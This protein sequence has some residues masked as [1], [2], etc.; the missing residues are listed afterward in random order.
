MSSLNLSA[1]PWW[2]ADQYED[3][4]R[5]PAA[6]ERE[7]LHGPKG[8]ALVR[9]YPD[10]QTQRGWGAE[11]MPRYMAT[12]FLPRRALWGVEQGKHAFAFVLR[13]SRLLCIDIDGKNGG[14]QHAPSLGNLPAT[15][16]ETSKSGTGYHLWYEVDEPWNDATG[17]DS[18]SDQIGI[19]QGVD[20]RAVGCVY[21]W[22]TQRWNDRPLAKLPDWLFDRLTLRRRQQLAVTNR[23]ASVLANRDETEI[24]MLQT[25]LLDE[26]AK[27]IPAGKRNTTLF[28]IGIKLKEAEVPDWENKL[29]ARGT[30][31]GLP[32]DEVD[33]IVNNV[34]K[35]NA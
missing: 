5:V 20:I 28:A 24:L 33:R 26:L 34:G 2:E 27:P 10:G 4:S 8:M 16:S 19:V 17:F 25:E 21:H 11:F 18:I 12:E 29:H 7:D 15:L 35:H 23:I 1:T 14:L 31:I 30:K 13:S 32:A 9:A 3:E 6:L 22:D